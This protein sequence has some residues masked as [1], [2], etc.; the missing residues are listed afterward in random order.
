MQAGALPDLGPSTRSGRISL[1]LHPSELPHK[2]RPL[3]AKSQ[4][5]PYGPDKLAMF[6]NAGPVVLFRTSIW[7]CYFI[8]VSSAPCFSLIKFYA[9]IDLCWD[10][11]KGKFRN[12]LYSF[13]ITWSNC[14]VMICSTN[15]LSVHFD[16][17]S[18]LKSLFSKIFLKCISYDHILYF[19]YYKV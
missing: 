9:N 5:Y 18:V 17:N 4:I 15:F 6:L 3:L 11:F 14:Y 16:I 8:L 19:N 13:S 12:S 10:F 1:G 7:N 2:S